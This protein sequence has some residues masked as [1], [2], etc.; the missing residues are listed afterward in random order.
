MIDLI[1]RSSA[2]LLAVSIGSILQGISFVSDDSSK[3]KFPRSNIVA[4]I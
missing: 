1:N 4:I 2:I 3:S